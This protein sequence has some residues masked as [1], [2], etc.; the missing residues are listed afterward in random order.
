M[1]I[2]KRIVVVGRYG[3]WSEDIDGLVARAQSSGPGVTAKVEQVTPRGVVGASASLLPV[4][5][6]YASIY[7]RISYLH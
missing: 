7:D 6:C 1:G 5:Y 4:Y 3:D 2:I